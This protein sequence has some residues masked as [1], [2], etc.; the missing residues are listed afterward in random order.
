M[1]SKVQ[2][3]LHGNQPCKVSFQS[4]LSIDLLNCQIPCLV[5]LHQ[6]GIIVTRSCDLHLSWSWGV[7]LPI[8]RMWTTLGHTCFHMG[9]CPSKECVSK[10][11]EWEPLIAKHPVIDRELLCKR[12]VHASA[13]A[14]LCGRLSSLLCTVWGTHPPSGKGH[15]ILWRCCA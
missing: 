14:L 11:H 3:V 10:G 8:Q 2:S 6:D 1:G 15:K 9:R 13:Y 4:L 5:A 7:L 12:G